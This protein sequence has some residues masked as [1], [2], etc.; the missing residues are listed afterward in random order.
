[1]PTKTAPTEGTSTISLHSLVLQMGILC[2]VFYLWPTPAVQPVKLM[3]VLF[4]EMSHGLMAIA[5]G[6]KVIS[7]CITADEGGACETEGGVEALIV[8][9]GYLG[10]MFLG[11]MVL[12]LSRARHFVPVVYALLTLTLVA[13]A[14]TVLRD[15][16]SRTFASC[17]AGAFVFLGFIGPA[18]LGAFFLRVIGTFACVYSLFDIYWD[19]LADTG[20]EPAVNDAVAFAA[21]TGVEPQTVGMAWMLVSAV[22]FL[23][24]LRSVLTAPDAIDIGGPKQ[25]SPAPA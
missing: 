2:A 18:A 23:V 13:A 6:G 14:A 25:S 7:I 12:H 19:V 3:V 1:M 9:V 15:D 8:S 22:F 17:L 4:H 16:Y 24:A 21:L 5:T 20:G 10:S 11:A